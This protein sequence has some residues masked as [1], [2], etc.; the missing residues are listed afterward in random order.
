MVIATCEFEKQIVVNLV[1]FK[2]ELIADEP[3]F[4]I[5]GS[6]LKISETTS[7]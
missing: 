5:D 3:A 1:T 2:Y 4:E 7:M 6:V